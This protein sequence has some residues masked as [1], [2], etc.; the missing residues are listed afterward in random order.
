MKVDR[1]LTKQLPYVT[2]V[3]GKGRIYNMRRIN[4]LIKYTWWQTNWDLGFL[5][6]YDFMSSYLHCYKVSYELFRCNTRNS[7]MRFL[8]THF[9]ACSPILDNHPDNFAFELSRQ[10]APIVDVLP[11][12]TYNLLQQ[13]LNNCALHTLDNKTPYVM[14]Y[15]IGTVYAIR[16]TF[17]SVLVLVKG[18][19]LIFECA[20][21]KW[22]TAKHAEYELPSA[23]FTAMECSS[24]FVCLYSTRSIQVFEW[25]MHH[26]APVLQLNV[27]EPVH[28]A[29]VEGKY[30]IICSKKKQ[31]IE[32]WNCSTRTLIESFNFNGPLLQCSTV[33]FS[34]QIMRNIAVTEVI[35]ETGEIYYL[36]LTVTTDTFSDKD[37]FQ[38]CPTPNVKPGK[39]SAIW[40]VDTAVY[41]DEGQSHVH[42]NEFLPGSVTKDFVKIDN[43]PLLT[44]AV[45]VNL[46]K[47]FGSV[48][49]WF[50]HDSAVILHSCG[51]Y[52][53]IPGVYH[54]VCIEST[55]IN[56]VKDTVCFFNRNESKF[57]LF[58]LKCG[59]GVHQYRHLGDLQLDQKIC[60][61]AWRSGEF[62]QNNSSY[63]YVFL[64]ED[65]NV[66]IIFYCILENGEFRIYNLTMMTYLPDRPVTCEP[67]FR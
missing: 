23:D 56:I 39:R 58:H 24:L 51:K 20:S 35:L 26:L 40:K 7:E 42:F 52:F 9:N 62:C 57:S 43:L 50:T 28:I 53:S 6:D 4:Q 22:L 5:F 64:F 12:R 19:L 54:E 1:H 34:Y 61:C 46:S 15:M 65:S 21:N 45:C 11:K 30:M 38:L 2:N 13:C 3:K 14:K 59:E 25:D 31:L 48:L 47:I 17:Y 32:V 18:K 67:K 49:I 63:R 8:L 60:H 37:R 16:V 66:G 10:L 41:Y 27:E 44:R 36:K 33:I 55:S 29:I